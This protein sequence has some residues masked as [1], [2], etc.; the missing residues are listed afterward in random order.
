MNAASLVRTAIVVMALLVGASV[1]AAELDVIDMRHLEA[2]G[3]NVEAGRE[4]AAVCTNCHGEN[5]KAM[6]PLF[7]SVAGL[8]ESYLYWKLM[9]FKQS[10]RTD[11]V[12]TPLVSANTEEDLRDIAAFYASLP[13]DAPS[14]LVPEPV[15][16]AVLERGRNLFLTGDTATGTPPCQGCHGPEGAGP[17]GGKPF[18][19]AWPALRGQPA[20]YV[21]Q[22]LTNYQ[23]GYAIDTSQDKIMAGVARHLAPEDIAALAA[24]IERIGH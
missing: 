14:T 22:R 2:P 8:P 13:L 10:T 24:Y 23:A 1:L 9:A 6:A 16:D 12:M 17:P 11:S 19:H 15:D 3:G 5:G 18:Q 21:S 7:P 4:K 20:M